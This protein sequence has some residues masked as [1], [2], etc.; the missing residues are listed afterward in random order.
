M[1]VV[2]RAL[3]RHDGSVERFMTAFEDSDK[4]AGNDI[5]ALM[6]LAMAATYDPDSS[7]PFGVRLPVT[8]DTCELVP[9]RWQAWLDHDPALIAGQHKE[10]LASL[11]FLFIDCGDADQYN[12]LY[13]ARRLSRSLIGHGVDHEYQEFSGTHS[14]VEHRLDVSL[15]AMARAL[16]AS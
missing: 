8:T 6:I 16:S 3:A 12:L 15:P 11:A 13:G 14:G 5:H 7:A 10:A 1:P 9:E 4:V 2:L